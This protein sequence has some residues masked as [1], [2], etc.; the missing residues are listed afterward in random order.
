MKN[1]T[2]NTTETGNS[3]NLLLGNVNAARKN[4]AKFLA[5]T[6]AAEFIRQHG[7]EGFSF[8]DKKLDK[9]YKRNTQQL[10]YQ[11]NKRAEAFRLKYE[12]TGIYI[13]TDDDSDSYC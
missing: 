5:L 7:E 2:S 11:L 12:A 13:N 9:I 1:E 10:A 4:I 6:N 8:R 3:A